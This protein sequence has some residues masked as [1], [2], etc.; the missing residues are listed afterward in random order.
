MKQIYFKR[1]IKDI[2]LALK[3]INLDC[4]V[5]LLT[6]E[7]IVYS[8]QVLVKYIHVV[9]IV[10]SYHTYYMRMLKLP[11]LLAFTNIVI[12]VKLV[13]HVSSNM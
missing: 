9:L 7:C 4:M 13:T 11:L 12:M 8:Y 5:S 10:Y 6:Y 3:Q 2:R 1:S